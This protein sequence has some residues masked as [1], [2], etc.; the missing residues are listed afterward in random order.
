[1]ASRKVNLADPSPFP[2]MP[3]EPVRPNSNGVMSLP[4]EDMVTRRSGSGATRR[5]DGQRINFPGLVAKGEGPLPND[6][7][8]V[9]VNGVSQSH[10]DG[11]NEAYNWG[12]GTDGA[13]NK[14]RG[15]GKGS[16]R[17]GE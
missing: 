3:P 5:G 9:T 16:N 13:W 12:N 14:N 2:V 8:V 15:W 7:N 11:H 1:M 17:T 6:V 10:G 4:D